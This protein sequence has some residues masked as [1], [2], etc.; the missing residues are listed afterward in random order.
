MWAV[1]L[2]YPN[3]K[4]KCR[5]DHKIKYFLNRLTKL[6]KLLRRIWSNFIRAILLKNLH[7][8]PVFRIRIHV[9]FGLPDPDPLVRGM[10]PP[11]DPDP[12][13]IMQK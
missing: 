3:A 7:C 9:F 6:V 8:K 10:D 13:T 1:D 12:S 4:T 5:S 11:L 2:F